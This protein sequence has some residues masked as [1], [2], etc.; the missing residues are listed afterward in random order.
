LARMADRCCLLR[1]L[2]HTNSD[3]NGG[4]HICMTG[5]S[6]PQD[7]TPC[8]GAVAARLRPSRAAL[9]S[10]VWLQN[11]DADVREWYLTGGF[12]GPGC[13]PL[14]VGKGA[15]N[16]SAPA[17]RFR[18]FDPPADVPVQRLARRRHLLSSLEGAPP[19]RPVSASGAM[20]RFQ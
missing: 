19:S 14:L 2:S 11:L 15:D 17:F 1:S 6:R 4:M 5:H 7:N 9:P 10:Y 12:L 8:F 13:A 20:H 18:G 3:H 16:P